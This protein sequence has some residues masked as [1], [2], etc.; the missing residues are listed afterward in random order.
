MTKKGSWND[1]QPHRCKVSEVTSTVTVLLLPPGSWLTQA[2]Q[3]SLPH[4][5]PR[6]PSCKL[7][8]VLLCPT[9]LQTNTSLS[10]TLPGDPQPYAWTPPFWSSL[11]RKPSPIA[12]PGRLSFPM[13]CTQ[14][15]G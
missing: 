12:Q 10:R 8:R 3:A 11:P 7:P 9:Q 14:C 6:I 13:S 2:L 5:L 15:H 1:G 4:A